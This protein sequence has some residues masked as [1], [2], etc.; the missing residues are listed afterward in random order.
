MCCK[1][2]AGIEY[3]FPVNARETFKLFQMLHNPRWYSLCGL[4][5]GHAGEAVGEGL[6][7]HLAAG[8]LQVVVLPGRHVRTLKRSDVSISENININGQ[9]LKEV[10]GGV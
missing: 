4:C 10:Y 2:K 5:E 7:V 1:Y 9:R 3:A 8:A 6:C